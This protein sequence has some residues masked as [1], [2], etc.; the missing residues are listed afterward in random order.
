[1]VGQETYGGQQEVG[2]PGRTKVIEYALLIPLKV[3]SLDM[4]L[5]SQIFSQEAHVQKLIRLLCNRGLLNRSLR[6]GIILGCHLRPDGRGVIVRGHRHILQTQAL[7]LTMA[8]HVLV[9][10]KL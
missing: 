4:K 7:S 5:Q 10:S 3:W 2:I 8:L 1:M 6:I 9:A